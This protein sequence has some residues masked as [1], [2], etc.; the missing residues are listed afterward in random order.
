MKSKTTWIWFTLAATLLVF[1]FIFQHFQRGQTKSSAN[2]L[3]GFRPAVVTGVQIIPNGA[4]EIR[5]QNKNGD[6]FLTKPISYPAQMAAIQSLLDA[7]QKLTFV[8]RIG[9]ADLREHKSSDADFG[10]ENPQFSIQIE[11]TANRWQILVGNKTPPGDQVFLRVVG[12]DGAFVTDTS[13]LNFIPRSANDWRD[14]SLVNAVEKNFDAIVLSN[15]AKGLVIELQQNATNHLW[16]MIRPLPSRADS[17]HITAAL[18]QLQAARVTKFVTDDPG[19]DLSPFG[20]QSPEIV[21]G[22]GHGT[23]FTSGFFAGK[24]MANDSTQI[25]AKRKNY[26]VVVTTAKDALAGWY[27]GVN[28]FRDPLLMEFTSPPAEI[29]MRGENNFTLQRQ[30]TNDWKIASEKFAADSEEVQLFIKILA[31]LRVQDFVKDVVT[32]PDLQAYGLAKPS[33]EIIVR[34][35]AGDSN[36]AMADLSFAAS[37]N[38]IFAHR[39]DEDFIYSI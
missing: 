27:G 13:W 3:G 37:T 21:L 29:E 8:T 10:F 36:S 14:T 11:T 16:R 12:E 24:T 20:L 25:F 34:S 1:I 15:N 30:G 5:A 33:R 4:L 17:E 19:A 39:A 32:A 2:I 38:G 23:N 28:S 18:Q 9:A 22:L 7:L 35:A 31:S 26:N 6:W